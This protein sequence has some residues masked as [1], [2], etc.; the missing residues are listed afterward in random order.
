V[1]SIPLIFQIYFSN[2]HAVECFVFLYYLSAL[3][4]VQF[5]PC[6]DYFI[7][8]FGFNFG[9]LLADYRTHF[10][11][12]EVGSTVVKEVDFLFLGSSLVGGVFFEVCNVE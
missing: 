11:R 5:C 2:C 12:W 7:T 3:Q 9:R 8:V 6:L 4:N 1:R 10:S